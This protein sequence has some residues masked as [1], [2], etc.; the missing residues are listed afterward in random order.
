MLPSGQSS[1]GFVVSN[2]F[3]QVVVAGSSHFSNTSVVLQSE[4]TT[5]KILRALQGKV[6]LNLLI[7]V[8]HKKA[9][10]PWRIRTMYTDIQQLSS[11]I[12][13]ISFALLLT[14]S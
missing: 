13:Q 14:F 8:I 9:Q 10:V 3:D 1:A 2:M 7:N 6:I 12:P 5:L 4:A 11:P